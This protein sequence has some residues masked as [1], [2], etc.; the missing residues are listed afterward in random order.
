MSAVTIEEA[1]RQLLEAAEERMAWM[2]IEKVPLFDGLGRM[3]ADD[4]VSPID[5]PPFPRSPIDGYALRAA[6]LSEASLEH[7]ARLTV[8]GQVMAGEVAEARVLPGTA[9]RIMTGAPIPE[10]ADCTIRQEDTDC[11]EEEVRVYRPVKAHDNICDQGEDFKTGDCLLKEGRKLDA[12]CLGI[13]AGMGY[14][15][16]P[17]YRKPKVAL[18]TTGDEVVMPGEAL[19]PGKIYNSNLFVI[20][21]RL[22]ELGIQP[23]LMKAVKDSPEEMKKELEEAVACADLVV[24]T[25]GVSV[26]KKD[27]MHDALNL[28]GA[29]RLFWR[30][31]CKPGS[32]VIG[33]V[34]QGRV[35]V[36]L[37]GNPF[38]AVA[39]LE[40][41]VRPLLAKLGRDEGLVP[42]LSEGI[43]ES[44]FKK[45]SPR[46]RFIRAVYEEGKVRLPE[47]L[48]SSGVLGSMIGCNC[49]I[50][51]EA[52]NPGLMPGDRVK[53][54]LL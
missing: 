45:A 44:C 17:V 11:G 10:G 21:G 20:G 32:P 3:L 4:L 41:L 46:R 37:S 51:I 42:I 16:L 27:I 15:F 18:L 29:K 22:K 31:A 54:V 26:G 48:H 43:M 33:S 7:P 50:D 35:I 8:V 34:Y 23:V 1:Q 47:G 24:T 30:I 40:L 12:V 6:D 36:S 53:T 39:N 5:Q 25:G 19:G 49:F 38:G 9:V 28:L 14:A 52:G 2:G 13:A